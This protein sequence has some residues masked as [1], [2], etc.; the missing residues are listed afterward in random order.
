MNDPW[1]RVDDQLPVFGEFVLV[2]MGL[3][4][5]FGIYRREERGPNLS[6]DEFLEWWWI[7]ESGFHDLNPADGA[8]THWCP[9]PDKPAAQ[10]R[11][12]DD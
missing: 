11:Q 2:C 9:L 3:D 10:H 5:T 12:N 7:D 1:I 4:Q 6:P 8:V